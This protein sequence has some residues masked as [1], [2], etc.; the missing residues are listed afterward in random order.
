MS[1]TAIKNILVTGASGKIGRNLTPALIK[2]GYRV[3]AVQFKTPVAFDG[4]EVVSG[5]VSDPA[6]VRMALED[7]HAVCHLATSKEDPEHFLDVSVRG[8]FNLLDAGRQYSSLK[9]FILAGGD[10]ALGIFFYENPQPLDES[11]PL[12]AYP[13]YY[14]FS[15]V[16]EETMCN[17]YRVQYGLP[18]TILRFS[19]IQDEDD[20][21]AYMTLQEPHFGGPAWQELAVTEGQKT[22]F[23]QGLDAVGSLV[24]PGG[25]PYV[26]HIVGV[27]DVVQA[28]LR[29]LNCP[30]S[31]GQTFN[32]AAPEAF[33]YDA[34]STYIAEKL[35]LPVVEFELGHCFD[36]RIDIGKARAVLGYEPAHDVF[37]I[38][39]EAIAFRTS[40]KERSPAK[41]LG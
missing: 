10:A 41:Y 34:L 8:T 12:R 9:Q 40:G 7:M 33:S 6:F 38:V 14:A 26:R 20:I 22:Y 11:A 29:A 13:G 4:A 27:Q 5:S 31:M 1:E 18:V 23:E 25:R 24:H 30:E 19:W 37:G 17:Q 16:L 39:D 15:K 36:F 2:A 35:N 3:R 32:I 28:F 21:L